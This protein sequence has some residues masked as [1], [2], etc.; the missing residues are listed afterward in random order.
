MW[1]TGRTQKIAAAKRGRPRPAPVR[2]A[3]GA[4]QRGRPLSEETRRKMSAAHKARGTLVPGTRL[5]TPKE[6][7]LVRTLP[8]GE[9][10]RRTGTTAAV[11]KG[12][13]LLG[14]PGGRRREE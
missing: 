11:V 2:E 6:D 14:L 13:R 4:A 7:Q 8:R 5:W 1:V 9:A 10:A 3:I 12:Q